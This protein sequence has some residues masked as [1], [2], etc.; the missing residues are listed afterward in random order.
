MMTK[1]VVALFFLLALVASD[2]IYTSRAFI[3]GDAANW[4]TYNSNGIY[5]TVSLASLGLT[6]TPAIS[7]ILTCT[8]GCWSVTGATSLYNVSPTGF[9]V[10]LKF[11]TD[12]LSPS[13]PGL[14]VAYANTWKFSLKYIIFPK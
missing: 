5:Q 14:T 11:T 1:I 3:S 12:V 4:L 10:Y 9:T 6:K 13:L 8:N 7:T 2:P